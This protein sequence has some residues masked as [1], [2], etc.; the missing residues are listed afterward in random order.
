M[1]RLRQEFDTAIKRQ[2]EDAADEKG[3]RCW[4]V[5]GRRPRGREKEGRPTRYFVYSTQ[6]LE[7]GDERGFASWMEE[8][9]YA[10]E[11]RSFM[12]VE[13]SFILHR[14]RKDAR[15]RAHALWQGYRIALGLSPQWES[16]GGVR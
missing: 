4:K 3:Q 9:P 13:G 11:D 15:A 14:R 6:P 12:A 10:H 16:W 5:R 2:V 7:I 8:V 1:A